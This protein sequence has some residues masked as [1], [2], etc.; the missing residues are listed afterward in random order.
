[1]IELTYLYLPAG[2]F[3]LFS[4][5]T[6]D[7]DNVVLFWQATGSQPNSLFPWFNLRLCSMPYILGAGLDKNNGTC[8]VSWRYEQPEADQ[9]LMKRKKDIDAK[10]IWQLVDIAWST[11]AV[12]PA[13]LILMFNQLAGTP[14]EWFSPCTIFEPL[15]LLHIKA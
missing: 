9:Y 7:L 4:N 14:G 10:E 5:G 6:V 1:M 3:Q 12:V 8:R 15:R 2:L 11:M 13:R